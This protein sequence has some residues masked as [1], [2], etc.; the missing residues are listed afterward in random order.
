[1]MML[2]MMMMTMTMAMMMMLMMMMLLLLMMMI[3]PTHALVFAS[4]RARVVKQYR[5]PVRGSA[6]CYH[7]CET[8][9]P[10]EADQPRSS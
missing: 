9:A 10:T 2:M 5:S 6:R 1:M 8:G 7:G 3:F 4:C